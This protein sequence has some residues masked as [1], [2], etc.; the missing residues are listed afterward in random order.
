MSPLANSNVRINA[1]EWAEADARSVG[2]PLILALIAVT[3]FLPEE[4]S[5]YLGERRMTVTRILLLLVAPLTVMRF[6][7]L[8]AEGRYRFVL[9]DLLVPLTG[10]WM[11]IGPIAN[12][13]IERAL[14]ASGSSALE[15]CIP[16]MAARLFLSERGQ[17]VALTRILCIVIAL[18]GMLAIADE[19]T[20]RFLL[21]ETIGALTGYDN[22]ALEGDMRGFLFRATSTLEHPILL[23]TACSFGLLLATTLRGWPRMLGVTGAAIGLVLSVSS[24]PTGATLIGAGV[25][26]YERVTRGLAFRWVLPAVGPLLFVAA[27]FLFHPSP[28]GFFLRYLT[29]D[30]ATAWYRVLQWSCAGDLVMQSP[31]L[32]IGLSDEWATICGLAKTI[33]SVWLRMAMMYGLPGSALV[34]LCYAATCVLPIGGEDDDCDSLEPERRLGFVTSIILGLAIFI[35]FTVFYWGTVYILTMFLMGMKAHLSALETCPEESE[36][37]DDA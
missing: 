30:P 9:P 21:R 22:G 8:T 33:D 13:G 5:F 23:G 7:R 16:Y 32:G 34:F 24:A 35:G 4:A 14:V 17:A 3:M 2:A 20:R 36:R 29:F 11:F 10:L 6:A 27:I 1:D 15:F 12:D 31:I 37:D 18:V 25:L 26:A 28:L 19:V